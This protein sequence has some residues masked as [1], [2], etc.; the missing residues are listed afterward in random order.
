MRIIRFLTILATVPLLFACNS[1]VAKNQGREIRKFDF[2]WKFM[3]ADPPV[4]E[5][6][7][8][9]DREW[10]SVDLPHDWS[11]EDLDPASLPDSGIS[12]GPF[13][14]LA[15]GGRSTGFTMGGTAWYRKHFRVPGKS[16]G[17]CV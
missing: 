11:I 3:K 8:F 12:E 6:P 1:P 7:G 9:N 14:S 17:R 16:P 5:A 10:R 15:P 13:Y 4:A 2:G